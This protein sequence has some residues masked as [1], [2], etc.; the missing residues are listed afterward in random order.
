M[1]LISVGVTLELQITPLGKMP[2]RR[3]DESLGALGLIDPA[4]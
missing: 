4:A 3:P 1:Q 2:Q